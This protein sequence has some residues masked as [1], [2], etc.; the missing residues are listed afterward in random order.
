MSKRAIEI[1]DLYEFRIPSGL[2][3]STDGTC[4][5]WSEKRVDVEKKKAFAGLWLCR[6]GQ[7]RQFTTGAHNDTAPQL[8]P[9]GKRIAFLRT[10]PPGNGDAK[11]ATQICVM[12]TDGGDARVLLAERGS[13]GA[14][15]WSPEGRWLAVSFRRADE[16]PEGRSAPLSIR[17]TRCYFKSDEAGYLPEDRFSLYTIDTTADD[18]ELIPLTDSDGDWDDTQPVWSPDGARIAFLSQRRADR[19][20]DQDNLDL[21]VIPA[22]GGEPVQCTHERGFASSPAWAPDGSWIALLACPGPVLSSLFRLNVE[23]FRCDPSGKQKERSLTADLDRSVMNL[24]IDDLWGLDHWMDPPVF[25]P[26]G[27]R[28]VFPV[29]DEGTTYLAAMDL[30][31][32]GEALGAMK[33]IADD[34][35]VV[36]FAGARNANAV[37]LLT[38]SAT[39]PGRI[40][41]CTWDGD[42]RRVLAW[43]MESYCHSVDIGEP[44]EFRAP[45]SDGSE[46]HGWVLL[47]EGDGPHPMLLDIHGGPVVQ[48]GAGFFHELQLWRSKGYA[49]VFVN[50]RGS[51]GYGKDYA[52][53][54]HRDWATKPY[55]DLMAA[56]DHVIDHYPIDTERMGVLGGSYGGYMTNW[57]VA[58][59]NRFRAACT[60]RTVAN[61]ES[62]IFS[63]FGYMWGDE[64]EAWYWEDKEIYERL[65]PITYAENIQTPL[66]ILQ[67][68]DDHRTPADQ[69]Q[70]L[71]TTLRVM[72]KDAELVLFP[73]ANHDLS[74]NG[75]PEQRAERLRV[76]H[77]WFEVH[78]KPV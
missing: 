59:T 4:V 56:V 54:I 73:G 33:R 35:V 48:F 74:R 27:S 57:V 71:Y 52:A 37:A 45:T 47:P 19:D 22:E 55:I 12:P 28:V 49:V 14:P 9:D 3:M 44:V 21:F 2:S 51:Q 32:A 75:P 70:R 15:R 17:V 30:D 20:R 40:E 41:Q 10:T 65:S 23:L 24:T 61:L 69:G 50:P 34:R 58:H 8:S 18:P 1:S 67:G 16:L 77:E 11:P 78:L 36:T 53:A 38:T 60:Q 13:F 46:V 76:I 43:P 62:M 26:D 39:E 6:N 31:D 5:V 7:A 66:L 29:A 64:L 68:L 72:D 25:A 63:D 42:E